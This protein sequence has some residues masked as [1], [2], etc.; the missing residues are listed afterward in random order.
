M[1]EQCDNCAY[2]DIKDST[3]CDCEGEHFIAPVTKTFKCFNY[4]KKK[5]KVIATPKLKKHSKKNQ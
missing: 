3:C 2:F 5:T 4:F 1:K